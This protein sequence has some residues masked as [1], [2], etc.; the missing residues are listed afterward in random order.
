[1]ERQQAE[2]I[3]ELLIE[4]NR[5]LARQTATRP[6]VLS[7]VYRGMLSQLDPA[8]GVIKIVIPSL[9]G[10]EPVVARSVVPLS[11]ERIGEEVLVSFEGGDRRSPYV[12]GLLWQPGQ[13]PE[14]SVPPIEARVDGEQVI[15][16]GK[17]E[18][19][20][21]CG[22]SSITLTKTGKV[23]VRGEYILTQASALN[24]VKG[25]SVQIN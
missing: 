12:I 15:I 25:G 18:I 5:S 21:K 10:M 8:S 13:S 24:R 11:Q 23:L 6:E 1:M 3:V 2:H 17:K 9:F 20:L 16:E 4:P 22:K 7:G 19:V 14:P